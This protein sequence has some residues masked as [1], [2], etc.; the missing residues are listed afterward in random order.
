MPAGAV[1]TDQIS[2]YEQKIDEVEVH[3]GD[4][5][6]FLERHYGAKKVKA[7]VALDNAFNAG[8]L[9]GQM[10]QIPESAPVG[11]DGMINLGPELKNYVLRMREVNRRVNDLRTVAEYL[12]SL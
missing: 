8:R 9:L 3:L 10:E 11:A 6:Q 1:Q 4:A 5:S 12:L 7:Q 2:L